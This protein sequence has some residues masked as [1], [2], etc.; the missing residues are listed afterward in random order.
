MAAAGLAIN[1]LQVAIEFVL[2]LINFED[3]KAKQIG[4][5][6]VGILVGL[7]LLLYLHRRRAKSSSATP[8][9]ALELGKEMLAFVRMRESLA[10]PRRPTW[11]TLSFLPGQGSWDGGK[12]DR[13]SHDAETMSIWSG[14]FAKKLSS[15]LARLHN[16]DRIDQ[17]EAK[18]L[19]LP[20]TPA[21]IKSVAMRLI[22]L[23]C[24]DI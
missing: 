3:E 12:A 14:R 20:A 8:A 2:E 7:A 19:L 22:D 18:R 9:V 11:M 5:T 10:P 6:L 17:A 16:V 15:I 4:W 21:E 23:G 1:P 13:K 24:Q